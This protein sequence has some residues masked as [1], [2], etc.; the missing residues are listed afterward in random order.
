[1]DRVVPLA[2]AKCPARHLPDVRFHVGD[3]EGHLSIAVG[4][5]G[6]KLDQLAA[7]LG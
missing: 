3:S 1:M 7:R 4:S 6:E 5:L 2:H